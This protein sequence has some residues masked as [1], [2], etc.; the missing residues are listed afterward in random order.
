MNKN[1]YSLA[2]IDRSRFQDSVTVLC[3]AFEHY[4]AMRFF[5]A[6][7]GD[8]YARHLRLLLGFF[9]EAR[10]LSGDPV[11]GV[12]VGDELAAVACIGRPDTTPPT[13]LDEHRER[14]WDELGPAARGRYEAFGRATASF[15]W[16]SQ[17]HY[18]LS[19][20]GVLPRHAGHGLARPLLDSVHGLSRSDPSSRG[21]GLT[22]EIRRNLTLYEHFGYRRI[23]HARLPGL[24]TWGFFRRDPVPDPPLPRRS[25]SVPPG[26]G[27]R[28]PSG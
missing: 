25:P 7:A 15:A 21:V 11:M 13:A 3:Q 12:T 17:P 22:T 27:N 4:P 18:D 20:I 5:L 28:T 9:A 8:R 2:P 14:L 6:D 1:D 26:P 19:L 10:F 24:D 23:G 16:P